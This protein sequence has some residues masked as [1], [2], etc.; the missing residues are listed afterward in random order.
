MKF[1]N[2]IFDDS[3]HLAS[4]VLVPNFIL[5]NE[6]KLISVIISIFYLRKYNVV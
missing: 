1:E 3:L 4:F 2:I 5:F 6:T